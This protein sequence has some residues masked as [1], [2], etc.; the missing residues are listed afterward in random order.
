MQITD[1]RTTRFRCI[2]RTQR[3]TDGHGHPGPERES[4]QTLL[5]I[6]TDQGVSGYWFGANASVMESIIKPAIV[7]RDPFFREEIWHDLNE[8]QRLNMG[9]MSDKVLTSVDLALW[10][11]AGRA[12]DIPVY[13][14]LGGYRDRV[15]AYSS[16]MCGD[17]LEN[18]LAT[19]EDYAKFAEWSM[20]RGYQAFKLHTWQPPYEGAPS[21]RRDLEACAAVREAVGPNIPCMLDPYHYYDREAALRLARGL[22][23]LDYYWMEEPMDEHSMSSYIW[24]TANT[25]LAIC[26][27]ETCEG[28]MYVRAEWIKNDAC[29]ISR[30][31]VGDVGGLTPL[32]K[33]I[34]LCESFGMRCEIHGGG[35]GNLAAL[36][37]MKNGEFY[38]R[39][40]LHP[41][42]DYEQPAEWLHELA[43]PMDEQG[44]VHIS[45]LPG[46][47]MNIDFD[48]IE[49]NRV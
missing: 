37:A 43:D 10:D 46:L 38:E 27:P 39:G 14:M 19:P 9:T 31:G 18:G 25:S 47:G 17:D 5:Q 41:F 20:Q 15:P 21:T 12:L 42:I 22:E 33:T 3:D 7:G 6:D 29:D 49:K 16:T 35:F 40:L 32:M 44:F 2:S 13:K 36:C 11:L 1:V 34:H 45:Q 30:C 4:T 28:K 26:G 48:Y 8:R 23:E 24:L